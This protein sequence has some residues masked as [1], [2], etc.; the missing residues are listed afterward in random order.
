VTPEQI[1]AELV[2]VA[3]PPLKESGTEKNLSGN[4]LNG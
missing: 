1:V 2:P 4:E 3:A